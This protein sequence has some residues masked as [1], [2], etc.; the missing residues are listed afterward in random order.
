MERIFTDKVIPGAIIAT[1]PRA[2]K[3]G[4][5]G[6]LKSLTRRFCA[7]INANE[8]VYLP[9]TEV[10]FFEPGKGQCHAN[11]RL[12]VDQYGGS[13]QYGW[14]IWQDGGHVLDAEFHCVWHEPNGGLRDVSP[15]LHHE[16]FILF[17]P[18]H[19]RVFEFDTLT[20]YNN[21]MWLPKERKYTFVDFLNNET[22]AERF[23]LGHPMV[24]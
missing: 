18:D 20:T 11:V 8:P 9:Y 21:R 17:L 4:Y 14:C 13:P 3:G 2:L 24:G 5:E 19:E 6:K 10:G 15:R 23:D 12:C 22:K 7:R 16:E 1:T